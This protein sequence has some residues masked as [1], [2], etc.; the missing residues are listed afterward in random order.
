[1]KENISLLK[2]KNKY[3]KNKFKLLNI[4]VGEKNSDV[5]IN[6]SYNHANAKIE[7]KGKLIKKKDLSYV[8]M[9]TLINIIK[10]VNIKNIYCIKIDTEGYEF[11]ILRHFFKN[12]KVINY[13]N[14]L[15]VEHNNDKK[16][17]KKMDRFLM[18]YAY[19]IAFNTNSNTIYK[20]YEKKG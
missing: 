18:N 5:I 15:I 4:A 3:I 2:N 20:N 10:S 19:E 7:K 14:M 6:T 16:I 17:K 8:K 1:L 13:P 12:T 9:R 11:N